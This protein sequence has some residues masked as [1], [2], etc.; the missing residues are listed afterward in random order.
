MKVCIIYE[1]SKT[2]W[3]ANPP[4]LPGVAAAGRTIDEVRESVK[5]A[6]ELHIADMT[7]REL[8]GR[9]TPG[10]FAELVEIGPAISEDAHWELLNE[11]G[12]SA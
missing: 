5:S 11:A 9:D 10:D 7:E 6:I 12:M 2:G 8:V 3:S 4:G 1:R